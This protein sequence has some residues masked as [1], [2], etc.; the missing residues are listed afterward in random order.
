MKDYSGYPPFCPGTCKTR[1][2]RPFL[3]S[4]G[5]P[6]AP[7]LAQPSCSWSA[8]PLL[9]SESAGRPWRQRL[10]RQCSGRRSR[11]WPTQSHSLRGKRVPGRLVVGDHCGSGRRLIEWRCNSSRSVLRFP[12]VPISARQHDVRSPVRSESGRSI[13][14]DSDAW[15]TSCRGRVLS[16]LAIPGG[17]CTVVALAAVPPGLIEPGS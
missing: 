11:W 4:G 13:Q 7:R 12:R 6:G 3:P 17:G 10:L 15:I 1:T 14:I 8:K 5:L 16:S 9:A 2:T